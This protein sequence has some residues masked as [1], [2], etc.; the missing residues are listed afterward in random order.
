M[1]IILFLRI[2]EIANT[3]NTFSDNAVRTSEIE[4]PTECLNN[5][6][7]IRDPVQPAIQKY[8]N[9]PTIVKINETS[10]NLK[11]SLNKIEMS[12]I[13]SVINNLNIG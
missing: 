8:T 13:E 11:F 4:A 1:E 10:D 2:R 7:R 12:D 6:E 9:H 3:L 5:I